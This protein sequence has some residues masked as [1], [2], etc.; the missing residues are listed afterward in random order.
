MLKKI[1]L[2]TTILLTT[3][4]MTTQK[5]IATPK[6]PVIRI[7]E[8]VIKPENLA[9]FNQLGK[10]NITQSVNTEKGVL[11]MYVL[12]DKQQSNKLHIVEVYVDETAYQ[13]HRQS[14]HFQKWLNGT[15]DMI[16][17]RKVVETNPIIFGSKAVAP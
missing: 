3:A 9:E 4:C 15:K 7:F 16:V 1:L 8:L 17:S 10:H 11:A 12:E 5:P 6:Q 14:P 2:L 13:A